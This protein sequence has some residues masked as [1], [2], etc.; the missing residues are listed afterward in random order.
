M[1]AR[2]SVGGGAADI[3][4]ASRLGMRLVCPGDEEWPTGL[5]DLAASD[6][7]CLGLWVR[8]PMRLQDGCRQAVAVVGTRAAT[9]YG[10]MVA[11]DLGAGLGER[12]W[13]VVSGLGFR[14]RRRRSPRRV[15][16]R[17]RDRRGARLRSRRR[18]SHGRTAALY[19]EIISTGLV[20]SEHPPGA[21][22]QRARFLV[23]NR[24]IAALSAGHR[25]RR[26]RTAQRG[27]LDRAPCRRAVPSRDGRSRPG[28]LDAVRRLSPAA[29]DRPDTVLVTRPTR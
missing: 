17:R 5:D 21:A 16:G 20:V 29:R 4:A 10:L 7:D 18:L 1:L 8:G 25:R 27:P 12:G 26:G 11:A 2:L 13:T 22:P 28:H 15:G 3:A 14:D 6:A 24:L 9:E 23:R 19:D